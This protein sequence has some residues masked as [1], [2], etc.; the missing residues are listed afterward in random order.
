MA[1]ILDGN[2]VPLWGRC[3][4]QPPDKER[5]RSEDEDDALYGHG[6]ENDRL[7]GRIPAEVKAEREQWK[8]I[9]RLRRE[10]DN[11]A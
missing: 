8:R 10:Q 3:D 1:S 11:E 7:H 5:R 2:W 6:Y 4:S 9:R